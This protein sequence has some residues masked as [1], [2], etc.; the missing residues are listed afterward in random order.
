MRTLASH[1]PRRLAAVATGFVLAV[2][3]VLVVGATSAFAGGDYGPD[4]CLNDYVWRGAVANDHLC[5]RPDVR[6]QA[7]RDNAEAATRMTPNGPYGIDVCLQGFVWR[8]AVQGD[9]VC[10]TEATRAQ[11]RSDNLAAAT[12]RVEVRT[13]VRTYTPSTVSCDG[14]LCTQTSDDA[15]RYE[16][17]ADRLNI[18]VAKVVLFAVDH[19]TGLAAPVRSWSA[20]V[21]PYTTAPGGWLYTRTNVLRCPGAA[22]AFFRVKDGSSGRWSARRPVTIGCSTL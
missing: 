19:Q 11:T 15:S 4:T 20:T 13:V 6:T 3:A 5:V 21:H 2:T 10:V 1:R 16:V 17:Q 7:A 8:E 22:N 18:G 14:D 9:H 12:R